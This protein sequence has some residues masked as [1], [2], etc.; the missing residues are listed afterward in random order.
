MPVSERLTRR[1]CLEIGALSFLGLWTRGLLA[2]PRP[3]ARAKS[4]ILIWLN[5]GLSHLD[6]F[7]PKP[8]APLE[9]RGEFKAIP[10]A[11]DGL[12]VC[13][14]LPG[15][16]RVMNRCSLIRSLTS[17]EG[18]HDRATHYM[19]TGWRPSPALVYPSLGSVAARDAG[20]SPDLPRYI[21]VPAEIPYSGAGYLTAAFEP[22]ALGSNPS[23]ADFRVRDLQPGIPEERLERRR[24]L[25]MSLDGLARGLE[26]GA[27][28]DANLEQAYR[29]LTA[30]EARAAF[31]LS[32]EKPETRS[33][34][35]HSTIGQSCLLARRLVEAGVR[36]ITVNDDGW[37]NHVNIFRVLSTGFPGKLPELDRAF[38]ALIEDLEGRGLLERTLVVLMGDFGRTPKLNSAGGRDHWPRASSVLLAGGG[39]KCG[40]GH[41]RSDAHGELPLE[42]AVE[43]EDVAATVYSCLGIDYRAELRTPL[44][45]PVRVLERGKPIDAVLA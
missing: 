28:R 3:D 2:A 20:P 29:L 42:D 11:V 12:Q 19:L 9:V 18:N 44:G 43:P 45:R 13:E 1:A 38:S 32:L 4:C 30:R 39:V 7:D 24:R 10:T 36:F 23:K 31:D 25:Q 5:G 15:V 35:G 17:P 14:H 27:A 21:A 37:D 26:R 40:A 6:S 33:R 22:F 34:Y 16:A 8:E 41:G